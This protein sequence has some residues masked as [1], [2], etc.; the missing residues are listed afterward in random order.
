MSTFG[1]VRHDAAEVVALL[2]LIVETL[3]ALDTAD[4]RSTRFRNAIR[5]A[6]D[7]VD[8]V[9]AFDPAVF[10]ERFT[11]RL[12]E[13]RHCLVM[14]KPRECLVAFRSL[15]DDLRTFRTN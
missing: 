13:G 6:N 8:R 10:P 1:S 14:G 3:E 11:R 2:D 12:L 4:D 9:G 5:L 15:Q 7:L